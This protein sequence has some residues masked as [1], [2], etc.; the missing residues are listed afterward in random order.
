MVECV[1]AHISSR[2]LGDTVLERWKREKLFVGEIFRGSRV[3]AMGEK[4][5]GEEG[6]VGG[7]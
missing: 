5:A 2:R 4:A 6:G 3:R 7:G 1:D